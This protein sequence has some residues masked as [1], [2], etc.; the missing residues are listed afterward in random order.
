[1][2]PEGTVQQGCSTRRGRVKIFQLISTS[3]GSR[4]RPPIVQPSGER[5][6]SVH[7]TQARRRNKHNSFF[8]YGNVYGNHP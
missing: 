5:D 3:Q 8:F 4:F 6:S 1:M 2:L 7:T